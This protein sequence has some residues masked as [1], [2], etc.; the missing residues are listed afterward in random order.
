MKKTVLKLKHESIECET[1]AYSDDVAIRVAGEQPMSMRRYLVEM[2]FDIVEIEVP[3]EPD[4]CPSCR[5]GNTGTESLCTGQVA[6][7]CLDCGVRGPRQRDKELAT[8][9]WNAM[10]RD[11]EPAA[12]SPTPESAAKSESTTASQ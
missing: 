3:D 2:L 6:I 1:N 12:C 11:Q 4:F 10:P 8:Q 7:V 9:K 5:S